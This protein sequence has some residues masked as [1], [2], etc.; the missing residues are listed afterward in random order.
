MLYI[1]TVKVKGKASSDLLYHYDSVAR[2]DAV[3]FSSGNLPTVWNSGTALRKWIKHGEH[4]IFFL[5]T[6]QKPNS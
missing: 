3:V 2:A 4:W 5:V 6:F 1:F